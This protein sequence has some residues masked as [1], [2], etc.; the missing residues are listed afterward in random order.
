MQKYTREQKYQ[1]LTPLQR[2]EREKIGAGV[3][4]SFKNDGSEIGNYRGSKRIYS[5]RIQKGINAQPKQKAQKQKLIPVSEKRIK[6]HKNRVQNRRKFPEK[7]DPV[8][9]KNLQRNKKCDL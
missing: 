1:K 4:R 7:S 3:R 6:H 5:P 9:H 2:L 8:E